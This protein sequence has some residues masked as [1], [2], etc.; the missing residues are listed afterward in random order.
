MTI[1]VSPSSDR[2]DVMSLN[3]E[4]Q[5]H[6][7]SVASN[8]SP[9]T[10]M[11]RK[12]L[13]RDNGNSSDSLAGGGSDDNYRKASVSLSGLIDLITSTFESPALESI[14]QNYFSKRRRT[15]IRFLLALVALYNLVQLIVTSIDYSKSEDASHLVT[16]IAVTTVIIFACLVT[17]VLFSRPALRSTNYTV[18]SGILWVT[19][20]MQL[21]IDLVSST[22]PL[23]ASDSVGLFLFF[24][25]ITYAMI[26]FRLYASIIVSLIVMV[27][28]C[29]IVSAT[30]DEIDNTIIRQVRSF[31]W[32]LPSKRFQSLPSTTQVYINQRGSPQ[33]L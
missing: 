20:Y 21:L 25:Y 32:V 15:S 11:R 27:T 28:H 10:A 29:I 19:V 4:E 24:I 12:P 30:M 14:Y 2:A 1:R 6:M 31:S 26:T 5:T 16:R 23:L 3:G 9:L 8:K 13:T 22:K 7:V 17:L 18:Q 33:G